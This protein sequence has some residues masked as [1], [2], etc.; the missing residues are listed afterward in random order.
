[1]DLLLVDELQ[2]VFDGSQQAQRMCHLCRVDIVDVSGTHHLVQ[3]LEGVRPSQVGI[4]MTVDELEQL[5]RELDVADSAGAAFEFAPRQP[6][7]RHLR[8][9]PGFHSPQRTERVSI[10]GARPE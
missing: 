5:D 10:E 3:C 1:M 6:F 9:G 2:S 4:E 8:L 7:A